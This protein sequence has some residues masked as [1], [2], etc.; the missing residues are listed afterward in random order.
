MKD[1][2]TNIIA[3]R[4]WDRNVPCGSGSSIENTQ[5]LRD[6]LPEFLNK[7]HI[8]SMFDAPCGDHSWMS[9]VE[10]PENVSYIGGDIVDFLIEQNQTT[11]LN[12]EFRV[13]DI[14][15]DP[16]PDVDLLF[17]R[18]CLIHLSDDDLAKVFDNIV[19][20][21]VKYVMTTSYYESDSDNQNIKTGHFRQ[22][23]LEQAPFELPPPVDFLDDGAPHRRKMCLW[24]KND[25]SKAFK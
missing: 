10:F 17:C 5:L 11:W 6:A 3:N 13:F 7:H 22:L 21:N 19:S 4:R 25:F 23:N 12:K 14:T 2:F 18:D 8:R 24:N 16:L 15:T 1:I 9:L 20:S